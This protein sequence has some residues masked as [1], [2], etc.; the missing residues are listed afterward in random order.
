MVMK[1]VR[2]M[3]VVDPKSMREGAGYLSGVGETLGYGE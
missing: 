2:V 1:I 3:A